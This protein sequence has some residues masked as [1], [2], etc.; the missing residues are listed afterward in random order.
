MGQE[1]AARALVARRSPALGG[2]L[3]RCATC[4]FEKPAYNSCRN[5][6]CPKCQALEQ[7]RLDRILP[8]HYFHLVFTLPSELH[9]L[10]YSN[11][12]EIFALLFRSAADALLTLAADPK[13]LGSAAK[14]GITAVLHTWT[15]KNTMPA[16]RDRVS[17]VDHP[18][19]ARIFTGNSPTMVLTAADCDDHWPQ[20]RTT[21]A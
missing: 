9:S 7:A 6:H 15:P 1:R 5:R 21:I 17:L 10:A 14:P 20:S 16:L 8:V 3:D 19:A 13:R 2:H 11:P 12:S 18:T 4:G